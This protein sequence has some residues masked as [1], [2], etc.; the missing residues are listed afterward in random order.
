MS[1]Q[2]SNHIPSTQEGR[3]TSASLTLRFMEVKAGILI[4][5]IAIGFIE[6]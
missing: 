4:N 3:K 6:V 2:P 1:P 5:G